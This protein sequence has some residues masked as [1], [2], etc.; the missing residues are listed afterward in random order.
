VGG[1]SSHEAHVPNYGPDNASD[2]ELPEEL[3][4]ILP[5]DPY[6]KLELARRITS[7]VV[8]SWVSKLEAEASKFNIKITEKDRRIYQMEE[9]STS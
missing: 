5:T 9:K 3:L 4:G 2:F 8:G 7:I 1:G 6:E